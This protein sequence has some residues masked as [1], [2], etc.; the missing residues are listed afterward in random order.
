MI[1]DDLVKDPERSMSEVVLLAEIP[2]L[3]P[4]RLLWVGAPQTPFA[5]VFTPGTPVLPTSISVRRRYLY[6]LLFTCKEIES[7]LQGMNKERY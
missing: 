4:C 2:S 5:V 7:T 6:K 3:T 1:S